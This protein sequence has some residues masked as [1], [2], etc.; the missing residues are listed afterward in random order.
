[1][2]DGILQDTIPLLQELDLDV[3]DD[4]WATAAAEALGITLVELERTTAVNHQ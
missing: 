2:S 1:L 3:A 4:T